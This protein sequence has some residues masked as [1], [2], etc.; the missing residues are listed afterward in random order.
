MFRKL[1]EK[2][3]LV[4]QMKRMKEQLMMKSAKITESEVTTTERHIV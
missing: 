4:D 3:V 2:K 1:A